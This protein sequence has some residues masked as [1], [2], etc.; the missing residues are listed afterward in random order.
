MARDAELARKIMSVFWSSDGNLTPREVGQQ[1]GTK[2]AYT[3]IMTVVVRLWRK[4]LLDRQR[5]G[6]AF[7][8]RAI[9]DR[10][11]AVAANMIDFVSRSDAPQAVLARFTDQLSERDRAALRRMIG[12][13]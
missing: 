10:N 4:G 9:V 13:E 5:R 1:L 6:N 11:E 2:L 12:P 7:E 3:T 8:Y